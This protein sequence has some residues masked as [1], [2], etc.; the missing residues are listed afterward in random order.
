MVPGCDENPEGRKLRT[1]VLEMWTH[2]R[3]TLHPQKVLKTESTEVASAGSLEAQGQGERFMCVSVPKELP[4]AGY[5]GTPRNTSWGKARPALPTA[6]GSSLTHGGLC[7]RLSPVP[8]PNHSQPGPHSS[9]HR[10]SSHRCWKP[11][12]PSAWPTER[13]GSGSEG[14]PRHHEL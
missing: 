6:P 3:G 1:M 10:R 9:H 7:S 4:Q 13:R 12:A 5:L 11:R 2:A 8:C 14:R